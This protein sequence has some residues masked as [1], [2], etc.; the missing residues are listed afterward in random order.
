MV[1]KQTWKLFLSSNALWLIAHWFLVVWITLFKS[2]FIR[3]M[4]LNSVGFSCTGNLNFYV[5]YWYDYYWYDIYLNR[6]LR[7]LSWQIEIQNIGTSASQNLKAW[8]QNRVA[9]FTCKN[10]SR[11]S[12][13][14]AMKKE[15]GWESFQAWRKI[16]KV[17]L[18]Y[19]ILNNLIETISCPPWEV[20]SVTLQNCCLPVVFHPGHHSNMEQSAPDPAVWGHCGRL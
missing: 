15:L 19:K 3:V 17:V 13:V 12:S 20:H 1:R 16:C 5:R 4:L 8:I 14:T 2:L 6:F 7:I 11:Y 18:L 9:R 10:Y